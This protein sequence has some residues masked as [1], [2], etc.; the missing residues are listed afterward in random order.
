MGAVGPAR[1]PSWLGAVPPGTQG[2]CRGG[3]GRRR[4]P[5]LPRAS[6]PAPHSVTIHYSWRAN[7]RQP[8]N[9][10]PPAQPP[11][12]SHVTSPAPLLRSGSG[13]PVLWASSPGALGHCPSP[14]PE[15]TVLCPLPEPPWHSTCIQTL[16]QGE[17]GQARPALAERRGPA[18]LSHSPASASGLGTGGQAGLCVCL[19][20]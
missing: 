9:T 13:N 18:V 6:L 19:R 7:T 3:P 14:H 1:R 12:P 20:C 15:Q 17:S 4:A 16:S 10:P 8:P 11:V 5:C 2:R